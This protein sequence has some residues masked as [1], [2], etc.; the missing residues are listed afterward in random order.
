M[1]AIIIEKNSDYLV[2]I[3]T[4]CWGQIILTYFVYSQNNR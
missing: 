2:S 4:V 1:N 3:Q